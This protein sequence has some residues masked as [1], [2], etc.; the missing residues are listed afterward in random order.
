MDPEVKGKINRL[1]NLVANGAMEADDP[2]LKGML[3]DLKAQSQTVAQDI[4][5]L[6]QAQVT[7]GN[8]ITEDKLERLGTLLRSA[9]KDENPQLRR[10]HL[11]LFVSNF[12]VNDAQIRTSGSKS[13]LART[14]IDTALPQ[15]ANMVPSFV[16]Q[17]YPVPD[18]NRC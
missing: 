1:L 8:P 16:R 18:S 11:R 10:A 5:L 3:A 14:A 9:L 7:A 12:I 2:S 17:W 15:A 4:G 6:D 13:A